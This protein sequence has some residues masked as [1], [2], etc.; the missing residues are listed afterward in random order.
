M[1]LPFGKK[2]PQPKQDE[3][4]ESPLA[5]IQIPDD[6]PVV[7]MGLVDGIKPFIRSVN[8]ISPQQLAILHSYL[9]TV[10]NAQWL[11]MTVPDEE[12]EANP[13]QPQA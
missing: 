13:E 6:A 5:K 7:V 3:A 8:P 2:N 9:G 10:I 4:K 1:P 12:A 11:T